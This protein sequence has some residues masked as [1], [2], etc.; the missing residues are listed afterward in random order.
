LQRALIACHCRV[1]DFVRSVY[2]DE[3]DARRRAYVAI[4]L[5][6]A[7]AARTLRAFSKADL[8]AVILHGPPAAPPVPNL[9]ISATC[10]ETELESD[11]T[12]LE[13]PVRIIVHQPIR[14][15]PKRVV[16]N[17][18]YTEAGHLFW[19]TIADLSWA[20]DDLLGVFP[21][22]VDDLVLHFKYVISASK[23]QWYRDI[24]AESIDGYTE[25]SNSS[26]GAS[27]D[28][29]DPPSPGSTFNDAF[30]SSQPR[31]NLFVQLARY[32][33][34]ICK[35]EYDDN[36]GYNRRLRWDDDDSH[37]ICKEFPV[38]GI[39]GSLTLVGIDEFDAVCSQKTSVRGRPAEPIATTFLD[40]VAEGL[41][42][43]KKHLVHERIK[44]L[45]SAEYMASL[46]ASQRAE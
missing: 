23:A 6:F 17:I 27:D 33:A 22:S 31:K 11:E 7:G 9:V 29:L 35:S 14:S 40:R 25:G 39:P 5:A 28:D 1:I 20:T 38:W 32:A 12:E 46:T 21:G 41:T 42:D 26:D 2:F 4:L 18:T 24:D 36:C 19:S 45:R 8:S 3:P 13:P 34:A 43:D 16:L 44:I 37:D 15:G 30:A 10:D